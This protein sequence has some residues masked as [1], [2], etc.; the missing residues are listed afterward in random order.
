MKNTP[1]LV[2]LVLL[3]A[4]DGN[5]SLLAKAT[6]PALSKSSSINSGSS[7]E[8][9]KE[10]ILL[11]PSH[12]LDVNNDEL[13]DANLTLKSYLSDKAV[14]PKSIGGFSTFQKSADG[15][16]LSRNQLESPKGRK[17]AGMADV[18]KV[19]WDTIEI[20]LEKSGGKGL[21]IGVTGG[22]KSKI[23]DGMTV[24]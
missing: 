4:S 15:N 21:G 19:E 7:D 22:P 20:A 2:E 3:R 16:L 12:G 9:E 8:P 23:V 17:N 13:E 5:R 24:S 18:K 6:K 11:K 14:R 10:V 1:P